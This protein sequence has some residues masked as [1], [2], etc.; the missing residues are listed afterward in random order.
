MMPEDNTIRIFKNNGCYKYQ[1]FIYLQNSKWKKKDKETSRNKP[2]KIHM[3][4]KHR[5]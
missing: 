1:D 2:K 5:N 3:L 4:N